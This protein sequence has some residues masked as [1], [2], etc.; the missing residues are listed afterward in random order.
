MRVSDSYRAVAYP[1]PSTKTEVTCVGRGGRCYRCGSPQTE[2]LNIYV[3]INN[4]APPWFA[5]IC[6]EWDA[7]TFRRAVRT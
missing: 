3:H 5:Q 2:T 6:T 1:P 4:E 7:C